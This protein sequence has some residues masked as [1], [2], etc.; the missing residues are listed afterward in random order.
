MS[1]LG[2]GGSWWDVEGQ[3]VELDLMN[4][5]NLQWRLKTDTNLTSGMQMQRVIKAAITN[6]V[7]RE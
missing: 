4:L 3:M 5:M 7:I 1:S 6:Q 2:C